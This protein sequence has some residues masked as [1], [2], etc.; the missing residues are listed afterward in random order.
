MILQN[1]NSETHLIPICSK[2][3]LIVKFCLALWNFASINS[4]S[5]LESRYT[6]PMQLFPSDTNGD[7]FRTSIVTSGNISQDSS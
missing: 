5:T 7:D 2:N 1:C 6:N 3:L 4:S